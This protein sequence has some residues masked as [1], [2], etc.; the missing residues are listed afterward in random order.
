M[1]DKDEIMLWISPR[2]L[3]TWIPVPRFE[4]SPGL[5]IQILASFYYS[6]FLYARVNLMYSGSEQFE[7][8]TLKV[9]GIATS[10]GLMPIAL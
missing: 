5:M 2:L 6:N 8:L 1:D 10:N 9:S 3:A 7:L 4:F